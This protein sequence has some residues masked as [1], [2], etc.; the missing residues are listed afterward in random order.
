M[1]YKLVFI[2]I[3]VYTNIHND[4]IKQYIKSVLACYFFKAVFVFINNSKIKEDRKGKMK[5]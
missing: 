1:T 5:V 2:S 4:I 3:L